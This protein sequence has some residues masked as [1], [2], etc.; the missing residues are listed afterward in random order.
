VEAGGRSTAARE[1]IAKDGDG[2]ACLKATVSDTRP[3][4]NCG[5]FLRVEVVAVAGAIPPAVAERPATG[6]PTGT[7]KSKVQR[8]NCPKG[9]ALIPGGTLPAEDPQRGSDRAVATFCLDVTEVRADAYRACVAAG[10]CRAT[11]A[12]VE[13]LGISGAAATRWEGLC[14]AR[15]GLGTHPINCVNAAEAAAYCAAQG[16]RL[17]TDVEW[18][19]AARGGSEARRYPWG[20]APLGPS[21]LNGCGPE[22]AELTGQSRALYSESDGWQSTAAVGS[23]PG[24]ASRWGPLDLAG[25]VAEWTSSRPACPAGG[26]CGDPRIA[27]GGG[28]FGDDD[29]RSLRSSAVFVPYAP[30]A[31]SVAVGFRCA[32]TP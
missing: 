16:R 9:M 23:F 2:E 13:V 20:D 25:N 19:Y 18:Q 5:A 12:D 17:P 1:K 10:R 11:P 7:G 24:G 26:K 21:L 6:T 22:C 28:S 8:G 15:N 29:A 30:D 32:V 4:A 3:P 27:V 14:T 31:R